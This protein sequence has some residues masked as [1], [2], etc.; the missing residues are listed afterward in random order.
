MKYTP[1][2]VSLT[3]THT[4]FVIHS[5]RSTPYSAPVQGIVSRDEK[6]KQIVSA[7]YGST[8]SSP[9]NNII[10]KTRTRCLS[11][12]SKIRFTHVHLASSEARNR[13]RDILSPGTNS[14][15]LRLFS[16]SGYRRWEHLNKS[17]LLR[18]LAE[19]EQQRHLRGK[20]SRTM[21]L[22]TKLNEGSG[23]NRF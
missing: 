1:R 22:S 19:M 23:R 4:H 5:T 11:T 18:G 8:C 12:M 7:P 3:H 13:S 21:S 9:W 16:S 20:A 15:T 2:Q 10:A 6:D 14:R 17:I